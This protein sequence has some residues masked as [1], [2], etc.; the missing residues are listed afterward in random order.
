[1][2][3]S[4]DTSQDLTSSLTEDNL[5]CAQPNCNKP[6]NDKSKRLIECSGPGCG[7]SF[8][9]SCIGWNKILEKDLKNKYFVCLKCE[10]FLKH[11]SELA[12]QRFEERLLTLR[13]DILCETETQI[14]AAAKKITLNYKAELHEVSSNLNGLLENEIE[15]LNEKLN[16][17]CKEIREE[18][19]LHTTEVVQKQSSYDDQLP[20]KL[21]KITDQI[22]K[23]EKEREQ[24]LKQLEMLSI[25]LNTQRNQDSNISDSN[26][27][28][29]KY[30]NSLNLVMFG[31]QEISESDNK[32]RFD[33]IQS[34]ICESISM[35][36]VDPKK[37][38]TQFYRIGNYTEGKNRPI[39]IKAANIWAK[40]KI[41]ANF[42][43]IKKEKTIEL[44]FSLREDVQMTPEYLEARKQA[45]MLNEQE[46]KNAL[47]NNTDIKVSHSARP[48]GKI[49]AFIKSNGKWKLDAQSNAQEAQSG[50]QS[51]VL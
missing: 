36:D 26:K 33:K 48:N 19:A 30:D 12:L 22:S 15:K 37:E 20:S 40:R 2:K 21:E 45:K 44:R 14:D 25:K 7:R 24:S 38:I 49:L 10:Y 13:K 16:N 4:T 50:A 11:G 8:H 27:I 18:I 34:V 5:A 43:R 32:K 46:K 41:L 9:S 28:T 3:S 1:M 39:I 51:E 23:F 31:I 35:L 17:Y 6:K 47:E 42:G 29:S